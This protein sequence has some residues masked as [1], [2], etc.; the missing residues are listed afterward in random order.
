MTAVEMSPLVYGE[1]LTEY[2]ANWLLSQTLCYL[3]HLEQGGSVASEPDG[4]GAERWRRV[5]G[6]P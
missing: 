1:P 2:N 4:D 3:R 6:Q 5:P